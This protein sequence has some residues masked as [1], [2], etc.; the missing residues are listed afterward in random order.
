M[1]GVLNRRVPAM[2]DLT[3]I[4]AVREAEPL[5]PERIAIS[6]TGVDFGGG[7]HWACGNWGLAGE[8][9]DGHQVAKELICNREYCLPGDD[10]CGGNDGKAHQ[11]RKASWYPKARQIKAMGKFT[12]TLPPEIRSEYRTK[13]ALGKLGTAV[14]RMMKRRG[15][16][17]GLRRWHLFGEDHHDGQD[18]H[19]HGGIHDGDGVPQY[20]PHAEVLVDGGYL[21][22]EAIEDIKE[23]WARILKVDIS[24]INVHYQY[25]RDVRKMCHYVSY[26]LRPTFLEWRW[27]PELAAEL[28]GF[29]NRQTWGRWDGPAVWDIPVNDD[30][31]PPLE[32]L[33]M[34]KEGRCPIDGTPITWR[35]GVL[36]MGM[37]KDS[38]KSIEAGYYIRGN[39]PPGGALIWVK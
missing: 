1:A 29:H 32:E 4:G 11:R 20:H 19:H 26:A 6:N 35:P 28:V 15:Y 36:G 7:K 13:K 16:P 9:E 37:V 10:G 21:E 2:V 18:H 31:K 12:I 17:R 25:T 38:W 22:P 14:T 39:E 34:L 5:Y 30:A 23:S 3:T 8:C 27:D 33:V 24:R